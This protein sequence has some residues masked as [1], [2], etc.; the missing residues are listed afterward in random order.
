MITTRTNESCRAT[1]TAR[2]VRLAG[3]FL[4]SKARQQAAEYGTQQAAR[5]LRK[6]GMP[7]ETA[8]AILRGGV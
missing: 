4:V 2:A 7:I 3:M 6:Q 8:L 5:N 1:Q